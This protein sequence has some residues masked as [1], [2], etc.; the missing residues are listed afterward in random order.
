MHK[1]I[2]ARFGLAT[3]GVLVGALVYAAPAS[4]SPTVLEPPALPGVAPLPGPVAARATPSPTMGL[5]RVSPEQGTAGT[6]ITISG[7]HLP[8]QAAVELTWSTANV[9]W[10]VDPEPDTVNYL[11]RS[12]TN[13]AVVI[14]QLT[15]S[16]NGS[17]SVKLD[18]PDDWGGVHDIYAV[19]GGVEEAHGG[20]VVTRSVTVSP[21]SGPIGTPITITYTGLGSQLYPGGGALLWDNHY[22]GELMANWTRGTARVTIRAAGPV[23]PHLI[24]VGDAISFLYLN[25]P[26]S[27]LPFAN[28]ATATFT[29]TADN[30]PPAPSIDWPDAVTPTVSARTTL[31]ASGLLT[32]SG[33]AASLSATSG[34]VDESIG[35]SATGLAPGAPVE[36]EWSTVVGSRVDCASVCWTFVTVP[37]ASATA[38]AGTTT[39]HITVPDGLGG[40]HVVQLSER[41]KVVAQVPFYVKESIVGRGVSSVVVKQGQPFTVHLKGVGWTQLDNTVAVDYDNSYVGYGCGFNSNGDVVLRLHATGAPGTHIIDIYPMLYTASPSFA[42]T[43]YG[44]VPILSYAEDDPALALGYQLPAFRLAI[45]VVK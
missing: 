37:L 32:S 12:A 2:L 8:P 44:M 31:E 36:A 40:W 23:G 3:I 34:P 15:T 7:T 28:G 16:A 22:V 26:Q 27:P 29:T 24:E 35:L 5:L 10:V 39:M 14:E 18:V 43:P 11:G 38:Q 4:A 42:N 33:V 19:V 20:F 1:S 21:T 17:F 30:G 41:G 25:L 6:P 9:T 13:F 45:T